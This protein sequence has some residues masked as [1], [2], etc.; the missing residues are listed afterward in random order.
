MKVYQL[1]NPVTLQL[2]TKGSKSQITRECT[3]RYAIRSMTETIVDCDYF[4]IANVDCYDAVVGTVFMCHHGI[5]LDFGDD[6]VKLCDS[7]IPTLTEGEGLTELVCCSSKHILDA[8]PL[9]ENEEVEVQPRPKQILSDKLAYQVIKLPENKR[10]QSH[11]KLSADWKVAVVNVI[12]EENQQKKETLNCRLPIL[13]G[14]N[15]N[16]EFGDLFAMI[17]GAINQR[18]ATPV[19]ELVEEFMRAQNL[20]TEF[21][22][23][24][25]RTV[26]EEVDH[27]HN[28]KSRSLFTTAW[29]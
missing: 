10:N 6:T 12:D 8:I 4:D 11:S 16:L 15:D 23:A 5:V 18:D 28:P 24:N 25:A 9:K 1:E 19:D 14:P 27:L 17:D 20:Y 21:P 22:H 26:L 2:G 13:S 7:V 29:N 3:S